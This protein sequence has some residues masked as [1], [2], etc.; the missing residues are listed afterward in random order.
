MDKIIGVV[1]GIPLAKG[2]F[3]DDFADRLSYRYT[4]SMLIIF[5]IIVSTKQYVGD[6]IQC[7][8][9][10]HFTPNH[11][12]Y[13]N[14]FCW[15]RNTYYLPY[16]EYVPKEHEGRQIIP[17]YQW[18]PLILLVQA[19]CFYLPILQWRT[20]SGRSG[21]DVNHIVEAGRMFTYAEHAEKRV[22]TL[23]HMALIL[24]RYLSSQK[25]IKTG[26][27]LSLKHVFS[28]TC[29]LFVG[30]RYGNFL[31]TLYLFIKFIMLTNVLAQL[32]LLDSFMGI[33]SHAYGFHVLASVLQGD[34]WTT[35]PR[36]PRI[37]MC[38]LKVRRLG[39][40]QRYT[41]QC[42][43][44][45]NLFN[46]KIYL[47][48]WFWMIFVVIATAA[49][50]LTWILRIIFRV[51]RYRYVKKH[52]KLADKIQKDWDR[53][54]VVKFVDDYLRQDGVLIIRLIGHNTNALTVTEF[55]CSLWELYKAKCL[56]LEKTIE[57][58]DP[59]A[60]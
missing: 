7:W 36:F 41:V 13:T 17:Y 48:I 29:C 46:E 58:K 56:A 35:S 47:F 34:D 50:L 57:K 12:E 3:D 49:S 51:D 14:D 22:D 4:V 26:C 11:E 18:I 31:V 40:V 53:K 1:S 42:V 21:I 16:D 45:I 55:V 5:A 44:P 10:A 8:V 32:F 27:T 43:L 60:L 24:N 30:R 23:N 39:N 19:L 9:P 6:P 59:E 20:F 54:Y 37:T 25:A 28:R 2:R 38:D 15:I 52:L 33:D